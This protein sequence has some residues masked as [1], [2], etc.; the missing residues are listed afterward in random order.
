MGSNYLNRQTCTVRPN[1]EILPNQYLTH[2]GYFPATFFKKKSYANP[3]ETSELKI[4]AETL[5]IGLLMTP[6]VSVHNH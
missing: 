3:H 2:F 4:I 6:P 5:H 1:N